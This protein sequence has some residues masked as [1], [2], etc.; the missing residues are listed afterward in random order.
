VA[1]NAG[2]LATDTRT[3][4][5]EVD[6]K[7][8]DKALTPGLYGVVHLEQKRDRPVVFIPSEAIIFN[9]KGLS[10]AVYASGHLEIRH[11][12]VLADDGSQVEVR[13]GVNPGEQIILNPPV[14]LTDGME[15]KA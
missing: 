6:V 10:A 5:A 8:S 4:L 2:A 9:Q 7:N 3:L 12:D 11:L 15:V 14:N 13:G 1:R